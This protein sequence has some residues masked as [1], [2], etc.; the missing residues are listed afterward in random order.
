[1]V[2]WEEYKAQ[3]CL[4]SFLLTAQFCSIFVAINAAR[5][6]LFGNWNIAPGDKLYIGFWPGKL[7][8]SIDR[9]T[10][11]EISVQVFVKPVSLSDSGFAWRAQPKDQMKFYHALQCCLKDI[12]GGTPKPW[13]LINFKAAIVSLVDTSPS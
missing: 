1:M 7:Y 9:E 3:A 11:E 4:R 10:G 5:Q 12:G 8:L 13:F 2:L 6:T